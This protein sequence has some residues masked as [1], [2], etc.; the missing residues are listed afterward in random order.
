MKIQVYVSNVQ[1]LSTLPYCVATMRGFQKFKE[2]LR[3]LFPSL[4]K[5]LRKELEPFVYA[6]ELSI[7]AST[8]SVPRCLKERM[9]SGG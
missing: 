3:A 8:Q 4:A 1:G 2:E 7:V 6:S 5:W 9:Y